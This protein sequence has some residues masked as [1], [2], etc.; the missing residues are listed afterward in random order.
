MFEDD[1]GMETL[2]LCPKN[3]VAMW[4]Q[5]RADF[6]LRRRDSDSRAMRELPN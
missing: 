5:Y 2:I 3:L 6:G 4:E 1:F